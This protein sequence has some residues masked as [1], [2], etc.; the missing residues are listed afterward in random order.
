VCVAAA[1]LASIACRDP[2]ANP[3]ANSSST[4]EWR[5]A[6]TRSSAGFDDRG[7]TRDIGVIPINVVH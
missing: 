7:A 5:P 2:I 1:L 3:N 6:G 4:L